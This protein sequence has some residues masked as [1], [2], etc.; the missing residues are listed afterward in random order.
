MKLNR[1]ELILSL[2][3]EKDIETQ[4]QLLLLLEE[5]GV[6]TTQ[7]T[8]S[9]DIKQL[10]IIKE[11]APS[12]SYRYRASTKPV[13]HAFNAKLNLIFK[14]CVT[15]VDY[16][17]NIIVIKTMPGLASAACA[18]LDKVNLPEVIG[19]LA[20]DDTC[21]VVVRDVQSAASICAEIKDLII[22]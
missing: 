21:F 16:A 5:K 8:I 18:A 4:E 10:R 7:A 12:G 22:H 15:S 13:E 20:G 19:T 14:Q 17:Q 6:Y 2:I 9:R 3:A 11:L 1:Q